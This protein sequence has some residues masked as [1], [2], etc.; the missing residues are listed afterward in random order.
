M[1]ME[2]T[3]TTANPPVP[4]ATLYYEVRGDGPV[5][6]LICGGIYDAAGYAALAERL[7]DRYTVITYDRRGN[8]RSPPGQVRALVA[9][10]PP[11]M[12]LL[13]DAAHRRDVITEIDRVYPA[14]G[15]GPAMATFG[16]A[17]MPPADRPEQTGEDT[18]VLVATQVDPP[19]EV[20]AMLARFETNTTFFVEYEVPPFSHYLP[21][22]AAVRTGPA[23]VV[24]AAGADSAGQMPHRAALAT[25]RR[26]G[27]QPLLLPGDHGGF[28]RHAAEFATALDAVFATA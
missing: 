17:L 18:D 7:A 8:S 5:V 2:T 13:P 27:G 4:G 6:L 16:A 19:P 24:V 20:V 12:D 23:R 25:A 3:T 9:H 22:L 14:Q 1:T 21:D 26:L 10:E 11:L 28:G 15:T